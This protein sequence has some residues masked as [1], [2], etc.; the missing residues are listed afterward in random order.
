M[1]GH[2][3]EAALAQISAQAFAFL[4]QFRADVGNE[5]LAQRLLL[6]QALQ[7]FERG[8]QVEHHPAQ[9]LVVVVVV[10]LGVELAPGLGVEVEELVVADLGQFTRQF[11]VGLGR[12]L[13]D[14]HQLAAGATV[15]GLEP[16]QE[17]VELLA[18]F[19]AVEVGARDHRQEDAGGLDRLGDLG[20]PGVAGAQLGGV[21]PHLH[22]AHQVAQLRP[23]TG[24]EVV[25]PRVLPLVGRA[26]VADEQVV[27]ELRQVAHGAFARWVLSLRRSGCYFCAWRVAAQSVTQPPYSSEM[28]FSTASTKRA[29]RSGWLRSGATRHSASRSFSRS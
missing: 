23:H 14:R 12:V 7:F 4:Q 28:A 9:A 25:D 19:V 21:A 3:Q 6:L 17:A 18:A 13:V 5:H 24:A 20:P 1:L 11:L 8:H 16:A 15:S 26:A 27:L 22:V 2:D 10:A 29:T